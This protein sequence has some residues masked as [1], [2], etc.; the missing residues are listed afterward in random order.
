MVKRDGVE[1][2]TPIQ[3]H[4]QKLIKVSMTGNIDNLLTYAFQQFPK[5]TT[6]S[7]Q[8]KLLKTV[9]LEVKALTTSKTEHQCKFSS[10]DILN[11]SE[12]TYVDQQ[13]ELIQKAP[14]IHDIIMKI[15]INQRSQKRNKIKT[16]E[17]ILPAVMNAV[18]TL[19]MC[20]NQKMNHGA[21]VNSIILRKGKADKMCFERL[22]SLQLCLSYQSVLNKQ[23]GLGKQFRKTVNTW[24][25]LQTQHRD[26]LLHKFDEI[27]H[28]SEKELPVVFEEDITTSINLQDQSLLDI[29]AHLP[30]FDEV[31]VDSSFVDSDSESDMSVE[32]E[33]IYPISPTDVDLCVEK[34]EKEVL[35][36]TKPPN[37]DTVTFEGKYMLVGD[38][39][40]LRVKRRHMTIDRQNKDMHLY[41]LIAVKNRVALPEDLIGIKARQI[42]NVTDINLRDFIPSQEEEVQFKK[43]IKFLMTKD[44]IEYIEDVKWMKE[45]TPKYLLHNH[46]AEIQTVSEIVS[47]LDHYLFSA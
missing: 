2:I 27:V 43:D 30:Q 41:N 46:W 47:A 29:H 19:L 14:T 40:D 15:A 25:S 17:T 23:L 44:L 22:N 20:R 16:S 37:I 24:S 31:L 1:T 10:N 42:N 28:H 3:P 39:L 6:P 9:D 38:N 33:S 5:E 4:L 7:I 11:L 21:T 26:L 8:K 34:N 45:F 32:C 13:Q 18:N 35:E 12:T 36:D